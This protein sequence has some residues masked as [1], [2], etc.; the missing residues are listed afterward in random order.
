MS[1]R[2]KTSTTVTRTEVVWVPK[3]RLAKLQGMKPGKDGKL[4]RPFR[5]WTLYRE[6]DPN[7]TPAPPSPPVHNNGAFLEDF[8]HDWNIQG[9]D[10]LRYYSR[11][12]ESEVWI[13]VEYTD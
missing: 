13:L 6:S 11:A 5:V 7:K 8:V 3:S 4:G 9:G 10:T 12:I 1:P 2:R